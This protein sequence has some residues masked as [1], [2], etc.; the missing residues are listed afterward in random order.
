MSE[1][2]SNPPPRDSGVAARQSAQTL[3]VGSRPTL[4]PLWWAVGWALVLF[5]TYATLA[6]AQYVPNLHL[7]DKLEHAGAFF[8]MTF[9]FAG[10]IRRSRYPTL[11][12]W[13]LLFGGGIEIAQGVMGLGRDMDIHDWY[14]DAVGVAVGLALAYVGLGGWLA[15]AERILGLAR[16]P[17]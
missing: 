7:W 3:A 6:P 5:I 8:G 9:W 17:S 10:L 12:L 16:E 11:A 4:G 1:L 2:K 13:M 15:Y 14:A